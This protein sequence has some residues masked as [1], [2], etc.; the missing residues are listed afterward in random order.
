[1][2]SRD[3]GHR[4]HAFP[5]ARRPSVLVQG[6][7]R[8]LPRPLDVG[9]E[10]ESVGAH[11]RGLSTNRSTR[12]SPTPAW[13]IPSWR[14]GGQERANRGFSLSACASIA[15]VTTTSTVSDSST[16]GG[17]VG[18]PRGASSSANDRVLVL[19]PLAA[20]AILAGR[21]GL[22]AIRRGRNLKTTSG[23]LRCAWSFALGFVSGE[24]IPTG[25]SQEL[26]VVLCGLQK[27]LDFHG[28]IPS[29]EGSD[30]R[31][32]VHLLPDSAHCSG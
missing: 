6:A 7:G 22:R 16:E 1:M 24:L 5:R 11:R 17:T 20:G 28:T 8:R 26:R 21:M 12:A 25:R 23:D 29:S 10:L 2:G 3:R 15:T 32:L 4:C 13:K 27:V 19:G 14:G 9:R 18:T 30:D 31:P